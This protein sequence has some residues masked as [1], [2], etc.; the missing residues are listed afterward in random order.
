MKKEKARRERDENQLILVGKPQPARGITI[1]ATH[2]GGRFAAV[3][4][5]NMWELGKA[6]RVVALVV[7]SE[8]CQEEFVSTSPTF[9]TIK[10]NPAGPKFGTLSR[11]GYTP[12]FECQQ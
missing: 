9:K 2:E 12:L 11:R 4:I 1:R 7:L 10:T 5:P 6:R 8:N 3:S